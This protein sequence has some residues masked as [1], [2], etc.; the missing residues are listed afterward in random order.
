VKRSTG[1][2]AYL[3]L[4]LISP[5]AILKYENLCENNDCKFLK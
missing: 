1:I 4:N 3:K 2:E 5:I